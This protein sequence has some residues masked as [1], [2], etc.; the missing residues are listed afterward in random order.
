MQEIPLGDRTTDHPLRPDGLVDR[1]G[2]RIFRVARRM[3]GNDADAE[4]VTQNMLLKLL[5]RA[6]SFRGESDPMGWIYRITIN[7]AREPYRRR[8]RRATVSLDSLPVDF[9]ETAHITRGLG[10]QPATGPR[11]L[12]AEEVEQAVHAAIQ[13]LPDG[14][15]E[16][17]I[18]MDLEGLSY[19][20]SAEAMDLT[21]GGF[22]TRLHRARLHLRRRLEEFWRS[23]DDAP[24]ARFRTRGRDGRHLQGPGREAPPLPR[25]RPRT[26][27]RP[28]SCASTSTS[29]RCAWTCCTRTTRSSTS[30]TA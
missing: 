24:A 5:Q 10:L 15:R 7:E 13:E 27:S 19:K 6:S 12:H 16:A 2:E 25:R 11:S 4:D 17:V 23:V 29:A 28:S 26:R 20:E 1:Y 21:L 14:Y 8:G 30:S 9:D 3:M 18:L 22:K